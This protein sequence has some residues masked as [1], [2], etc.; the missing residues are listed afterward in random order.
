MELVT[1]ENVEE[2]ETEEEGTNPKI[3]GELGGKVLLMLAASGVHFGAEHLITGW[4]K[5]K[6]KE[7]VTDEDLAKTLEDIGKKK[8]FIGAIELVGG[9]FGA[10]LGVKYLDGIASD[11]VVGVSAG[12]FINGG[13]NAIEAYNTL[14]AVV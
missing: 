1:K 9:V 3:Y 2:Q 10:F 11:L 4:E 12:T 13:T 8:G 14:T 6:V 7:A 5:A